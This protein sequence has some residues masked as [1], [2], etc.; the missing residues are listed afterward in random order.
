MR[1]IAIVALAVIA[2]I[3]YGIL[4]DQITARV[5]VEYFTI[6]HPRIFRTESPTL[7]AIGWGIVA[8]WWF[9]L[10]LGFSLACA[11]RLGDR[12]KRSARELVRP[13]L[14]LLA[15]TGA[16]AALAGV[17][18]YVLVHSNAIVVDPWIVGHV[19]AEARFRFVADWWAHNTSY[20]AGFVGSIIL[21]IWVWIDRGRKMKNPGR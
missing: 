18:G 9:A 15:C 20:A 11:S 5:C 8:T 7:L 10:P 3:S 21:C 17:S 1:F 14:L 6:G 12:P 13:L 4:H 16:A 2:A 19:P